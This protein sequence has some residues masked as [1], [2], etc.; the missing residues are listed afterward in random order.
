MKNYLLGL[1]AGSLLIT[2][3][4]GCNNN[5]EQAEKFNREKDSLVNDLNIKNSAIDSFIGSFNDIEENLN[6]IKEKESVITL[7]TQSKGE[8]KGD[9]KERIKEDIQSINMLMNENREK[10]TD[11]NEKLKKAGNK[12]GS[13]EKMIKNLN[14]HLAEKEKQLTELRQ[15][16]DSLNVTVVTLRTSIDTLNVNNTHK[17]KVID[18]QTNKLN[19]AYYAIGTY[20]MLK[21]KNVLNKEGGFLGLGKE[22]V[23]KKDFNTGYFTQIDI[24]K[25]SMIPI[26]DK[27]A[28]LLTSHPS[29][30]YRFDSNDKK[31]LTSLVITNSEKF[32]KASK[33]CVIVTE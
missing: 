15:Q 19:T 6:T 7:N 2:L 5:K 33:Y 25:T 29:D 8:L 22:K 32:W 30:S 26:M 4:A 3:I 28:K 10:I 20:K 13:L 24:T 16:L 12:A 31:V 1:C 27:K 14:I 17:S 9:A 11:L 23:L 21:E 18:E